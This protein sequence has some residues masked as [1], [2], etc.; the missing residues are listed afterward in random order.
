MDLFPTSMCKIRSNLSIFDVSIRFGILLVGVFVSVSCLYSTR[1]CMLG[2]LLVG[3]FVSVSCLYSTRGC[4]LGI[5]LV[6]VF[7]SVSCLYS[8]RGCMLG[9]LLVSVF[10]SVSCLYSTLGC[11]VWL[12][13]SKRS[14][15][16]DNGGRITGVTKGAGYNK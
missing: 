14:W 7:V 16:K 6:G 3:V 15:L 4:M 1:G 13:T 2:I 9:I 5:L 12:G 10:V 11:I 8:T